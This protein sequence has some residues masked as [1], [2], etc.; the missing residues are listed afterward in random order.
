MCRRYSGRMSTTSTSVP[1]IAPAASPASAP[2][3]KRSPSE[4]I[5]PSSRSVTHH[6]TYAP[7]VRNAPC[8][9]FSTPMSP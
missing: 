4:A 2:I 7:I 9:K 6:E 8:A 3:R 5:W 1:T